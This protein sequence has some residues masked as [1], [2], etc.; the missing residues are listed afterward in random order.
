MTIYSPTA[1]VLKEYKNELAPLLK[2]FYGPKKN[3]TRV[4]DIRYAMDS[5]NTIRA[6]EQRRVKLKEEA[7][8]LKEEEAHS[9]KEERTLLDNLGDNKK[10]YVVKYPL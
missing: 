3:S 9:L 1:I 7:H 4:K 5:V 6:L 8:S 10:E 2:L